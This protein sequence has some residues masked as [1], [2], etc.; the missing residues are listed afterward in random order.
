M[1]SYRGRLADG[2]S[3]AILAKVISRANQERAAQVA[4]GAK[5]GQPPA[6]IPFG[7]I[8]RCEPTASLK[9]C[10]Y[11]GEFWA[12]AAGTAITGATPG[13]VQ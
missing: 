5:E 7:R 8:L 13:A 10:G 6:A 3:E 1:V 2:E 9:G 12:V 4:G 11:F